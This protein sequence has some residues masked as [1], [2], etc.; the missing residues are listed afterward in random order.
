MTTRRILHC[1]I[2]A[3]AFGLFVSAP[4]AVFAQEALVRAKGLYASADYEEALKLLDGLK[5]VNANTEAHAYQV[6][7]LVALGRRDE[8]R[9]AIE[10]IV[11]TDPLFRP[12]EG[13]VSPRIRTFFDDVRKPLLPE[14]VRQSYAIAKSAYEKK[15]WTPAKSGFD[16]VISLLDEIGGSDQG[17][18]DLRTLADGFRDLASAALRPPTPTPPPAPAPTPSPTP[19]APPPAPVI[20][21]DDDAGI[22]R[23]VAV[24]NPLP[25]WHPNTIEA[26]M[27]FAGTIALVVTE[28]GKV[29]SVF[30]VKSVNA[31]YD[32][33]LL[34]AAKK[35][36]FRPAT[37]NGTPVK[38]RYV[39]AVK[40]TGR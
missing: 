19:V 40:L 15:D 32:T 38:F 12:A 14:I 13:Q 31:R 24:S 37:K 27:D 23:A 36:Q 10:S 34:E 3:F 20:Y 26:K 8:A 1:S 7:C 16:R 30:L 35:W 5:G 9:A 17:V 4:S 6:F 39:L 18:A 11:R 33:L 21:T 29:E 28:D 25:E 2:F 22:T